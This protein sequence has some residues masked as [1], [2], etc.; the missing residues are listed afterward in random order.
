MVLQVPEMALARGSNP[1]LRSGLDSWCRRCHAEAVREWRLKNPEHVERYDA[2]RRAEYRAEHPLP[3]RPCVVC[4]MPFAG[5][6]DAL[7]CGEDCR[8][9][10]KIEQRRALRETAGRARRDALH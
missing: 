3:T 4:G 5:R 9:L 7:V 8:R 1:N 10:R 6:P 2:Q